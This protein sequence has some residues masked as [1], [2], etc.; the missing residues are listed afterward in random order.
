MNYIEDLIGAVIFLVSDVSN[1]V[2]GQNLYVDDGCLTK[3]L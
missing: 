1:F 3:G 2:T